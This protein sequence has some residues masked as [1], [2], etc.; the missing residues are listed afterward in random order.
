MIVSFLFFYYPPNAVK[1]LVLNHGW[2]LVG[3]D[4][5]LDGWVYWNK[6]IK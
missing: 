3:G 4:G 6:L 5:I 2:Y 1:F